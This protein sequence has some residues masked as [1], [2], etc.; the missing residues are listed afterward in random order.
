VMT[1]SFELDGQEF[2]AFPPVP[3]GAECQ[4]PRRD[5]RGKSRSCA[6]RGEFQDVWIIGDKQVTASVERQP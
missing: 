5:P 1:V 3:V 6:I 4:V 2:V